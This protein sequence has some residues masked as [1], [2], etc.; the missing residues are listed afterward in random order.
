MTTHKYVL[1]TSSHQ[2]NLLEKEMAHLHPNYVFEHIDVS[3]FI[4]RVTV[5]NFSRKYNYKYF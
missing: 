2:C 3:H 1:G 4:L 5:T